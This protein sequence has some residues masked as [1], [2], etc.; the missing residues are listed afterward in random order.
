MPS[1]KQ[2]EADI[3]SI[4]RNA[5]YPQGASLASAWLGIYQSLMWYEEIGDAN[6]DF[7]PHVIDADKLRFSKSKS[8]KSRKKPS[9]W[10]TRAKR[11]ED[12]LALHL[13]CKSS[14]V[15]EHVDAL[16]RQEEYRLLQRQNPLGIAFTALVAH[17][18]RTYGNGK[19]IYELEVKADRIFP[20]I[21]MPG[22]SA[23]PFI[24]I[25]VCREDKP[26]AIISSKWS[27]RHDRIND[28]TNECP[29]Y[30][31]AALRHRSRLRFYVVSNEF[32]P[33]RL[34]RILS[35]DCVDGLAHVRK[36]A[37]TKVCELDGRL[38]RL[39]DLTDLVEA[40]FS[41]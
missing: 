21:A 27:L 33:S 5:K 23:S 22:R 24:D 39:M 9:A 35:D 4:F 12:Y 37:V 7:L 32:D 28:I 20:G 19:I 8:G 30:K 41:W 29:I 34:N 18:L 11:F 6:F 26:I 14:E 13:G 2:T 38:D 10:Q 36:E 40:T 17:L 1:R 15:K 25:L 3:I 16:M 31:A